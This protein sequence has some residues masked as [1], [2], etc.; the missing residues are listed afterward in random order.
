MTGISV[1]KFIF[2]SELPN[3]RMPF[4]SYFFNIFAYLF[5]EKIHAKLCFNSYF[6]GVGLL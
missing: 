3:I 4:L 5:Y 1:S 2:L 6:V